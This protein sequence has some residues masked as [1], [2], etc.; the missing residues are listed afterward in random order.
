[1]LSPKSRKT[2]DVTKKKFRKDANKCIKDA[3]R[4]NSFHFE[5]TSIIKLHVIS[6]GADGESP[7]CYILQVDE[8]RLMLDAGWDINYN[9][10]NH[11]KEI[12]K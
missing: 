12:K 2:F 10:A 4:R 11:I 8:L 5:M 1:M 3:K 6:G 7:Q 9:S